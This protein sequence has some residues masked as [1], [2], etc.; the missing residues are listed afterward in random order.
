MHIPHKVP[1][2]HERKNLSLTKP[3]T[4]KNQSK[5]VFNTVIIS[6]I[7]KIKIIFEFFVL[8]KRNEI[9]AKLIR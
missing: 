2:S 9:K 8:H 4:T 3:T 5:N 1:Q 7:D 6:R